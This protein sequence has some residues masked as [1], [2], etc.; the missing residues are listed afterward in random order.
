MIVADGVTREY[1]VHH[2]VCPLSFDADGT[3]RVAATTDALLDDALTGFELCV[4]LRMRRSRLSRQ[5]G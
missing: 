1:L 3:L 2:R 4:W 5:L